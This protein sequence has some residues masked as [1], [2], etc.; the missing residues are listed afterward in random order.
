MKLLLWLLALRGLTAVAQDASWEDLLRLGDEEARQNHAPAALKAFSEADRLKPGHAPILVRLSEQTSE[1]IDETHPESAAKAVAQTAFEYAKTA[2]ALDS[3]NA[4]AHLSLA[5]AYGRLT[6]FVGN[7]EKLQ[8][9]K[10]LHEEALAAL[11][12]DGN[13]DMTWYVLGRWN[14]GIANVN[15]VLKAMARVIYGA[16]PPASNEEALRCLR[17]AC[18][19]APEKI[20]HHSELARVYTETGQKDLARAEWKAVLTLPART[21]DDPQEKREAQTALKGLGKP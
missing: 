6:D 17:K 1:L 3:K 2:V 19:L 11:A 14:Y 7:R 21:K 16:L 4:R 13:D 8:Y 15:A 18:T 12:L 10:S 9:S 20:M 5:I